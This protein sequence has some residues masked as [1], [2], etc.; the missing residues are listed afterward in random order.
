MKELFIDN[1]AILINYLYIIN[2]CFKKYILWIHVIHFLWI[3]KKNILQLKK[4]K[5]SDYE[6]NNLLRGS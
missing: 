3:R 5:L 2:Y 1:N 4:P 6:I